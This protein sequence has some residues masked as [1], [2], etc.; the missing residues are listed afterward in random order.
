MLDE[1]L[2]FQFVYLIFISFDKPCNKT[3]LENSM[4]SLG[5]SSTFLKL[6]SYAV[7]FRKLKLSLKQ[8]QNFN[9]NIKLQQINQHKRN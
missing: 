6:L 9:Q 7:G 5:M 8:F 2:Y 3:F 1:D 4:T